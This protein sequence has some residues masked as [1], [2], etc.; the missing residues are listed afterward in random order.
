MDVDRPEPGG[1]PRV[2]VVE[3]EHMRGALGRGGKRRAGATLFCGYR[4][5]AASRFSPACLPVINQTS[6]LHA[7]NAAGWLAHAPRQ[8]ATAGPRTCALPAG[9]GRYPCARARG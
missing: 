1:A 2:V 8:T 6:T 3:L 7:S 5:V 9:A 4:L